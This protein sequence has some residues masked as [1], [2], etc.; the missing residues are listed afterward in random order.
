MSRPWPTGRYATVPAFPCDRKAG[1]QPTFMNRSTASQ[2]H[3]T[4]TYLS[5]VHYTSIQWVVGFLM[6]PLWLLPSGTRRRGPKDKCQRSGGSWCLQLRDRRWKQ[7]V[8][9]KRPCIYTGLH[10]E[11]ASERTRTDK[12]NI[13]AFTKLERQ[14]FGE[15][16]PSNI[17][18]LRGLA[19]Y[20]KA[21]S[22]GWN[23]VS[24]ESTRPQLWIENYTNQNTH[25]S[26]TGIS[27][28]QPQQ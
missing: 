14:Q 2:P 24:P 20:C 28:L 5:D 23:F 12:A 25:L 13:N 17:K 15:D 6:W 3:P 21:F 10:S 22:C 1:K 8:L 16:Q 19:S 7:H 18:S 26:W 9:P 27:A 4:L 11:I